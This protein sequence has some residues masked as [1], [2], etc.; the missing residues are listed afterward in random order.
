MKT[1]VEQLSTYKSVHLDADNIKTHFIG[2][3]TIIWSIFVWFS[4]LRFPVGETGMELSFGYVFAAV[5]LIYY[6]LLHLG[7]AIGMVLFIAPVIYSANLVA[8]TLYGGWIALAVFVFGWVFQL[9]GH[10]FEKAKPAF[11]DDLNQLL[12][13]PLFLMAEIFFALGL[14]KN[15]ENEITGKAIAIRQQFDEA[16]EA[17]S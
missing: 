1:I 12:I 5:V 14:L 4:M 17:K 8:Q 13:G 15:L 10:K 11:I 2:V 3:P 16:K 9:V 7:L 6:V